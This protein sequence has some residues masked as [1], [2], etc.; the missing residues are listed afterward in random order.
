MEAY[1]THDTLRLAGSQL[2]GSSH[3][4]A[5]FNTRDEHYDVLM[6]FI[7]V[8]FAAGEKAFHI[9]D[10]S[11]HDDHLRRLG[12]AG[13][14]VENALASG[15]LEVRP[16]GAMYLRNGG[17]YQDAMLELVQEVLGAGQAHRRRMRVVADMEWALSEAPGVEDIV[18]YE[19]RL[20]YIL[21]NF[22]DVV[23]CTY[24][25]SRFRAN[26]MV[27]ILRTHP[28][29]IIGGT[30]HS[31]PFYVPPDQFLQELRSRSQVGAAA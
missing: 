10:P 6:P 16:W 3:V 19:A 18:E 29:V 13:I 12:A 24:D 20:N 25:C 8:G 22:D 26:M 23:I 21:P 5:F 30:L 17:F 9:G 2:S 4:C 11:L 14:D 28:L 31:N 15:Q 7:K 27:D 1:D